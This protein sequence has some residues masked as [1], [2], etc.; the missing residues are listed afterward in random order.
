MFSLAP[1][2]NNRSSAKKKKIKVNIIDIITKNEKEFP[3]VFSALSFSPFPKK[4]D[5]LGAAPILTNA[6]KAEISIISGKHTPT[7]VRANLPTSAIWPIYIL[8]TKLYN[9]LIICA[10]IAGTA[11]L[12]SNLPTLQV[13]NS[14]V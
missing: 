2:I 5:A 9:K 14:S 4:M 10:A 1:K 3:K 7:P 6:A 13:P 11:N 12:K 8:S